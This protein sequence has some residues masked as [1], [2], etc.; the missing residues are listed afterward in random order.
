MLGTA[1][2]RVSVTAVSGSLGGSTWA[3]GTIAV[4]EVVIGSD[5]TA[6]VSF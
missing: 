5:G 4:T 3:E 1:G 2:E 6:T